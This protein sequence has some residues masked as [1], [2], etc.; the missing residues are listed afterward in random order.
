MSHKVQNVIYNE[1]QFALIISHHEKK[2]CQLTNSA[3]LN[4]ALKS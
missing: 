4:N 3:I 2:I 1:N